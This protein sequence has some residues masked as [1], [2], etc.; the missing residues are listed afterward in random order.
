MKLK[1]LT[2]DNE[3]II[4]NISNKEIL[5]LYFSGY[6]LSA[7]ILLIIYLIIVSIVMLIM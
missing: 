7:F 4:Y 1:L 5:K 6:F 3:E 2:D